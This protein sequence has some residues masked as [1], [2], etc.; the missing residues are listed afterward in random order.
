MVGNL[1]SFPNDENGDVLRRMARHGDDL[2]QARAIEFAHVFAD[3]KA[4]E[5]FAAEASGLGYQS[6]VEERDAGKG[7]DVICAKVMLP[8]HEGITKAE[9]SVQPL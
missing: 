4:A 8:T 7:W 1:E 6:S 3:K 2:S 9:V 5:L